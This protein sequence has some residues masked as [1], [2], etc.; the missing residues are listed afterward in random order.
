[1]GIAIVVIIL[2]GGGLFYIY[3]R[4]KSKLPQTATPVINTNSNLN[5]STNTNSGTTVS[6]LT[7]VDPKNIFAKSATNF[8]V[9]VAKVQD[10]HNDAKLTAFSVKIPGDLN[11]DNVEESYVFTSASEPANF[12]VI[13]ISQRNSN[14]IR[15]ITPKTDYLTPDLSP[16]DSNYYRIGYAGAFQ[17]AEQ[18]G[19]KNIRESGGGMVSVSAMLSMGT[20]NGWLWW[21]VTYTNENTGQT[22]TIKINASSGEVGLQFNTNSSNSNSS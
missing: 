22:S 4:N 6:N 13:T 17:T 10:W 12:W 1:M 20:P 18:N 5:S 15:F 14:F 7:N 19:G 3:Q 9:A 11:P 2:I 8:E 21:A 16:I